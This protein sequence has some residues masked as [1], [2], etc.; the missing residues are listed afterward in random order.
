LAKDW[1]AVSPGRVSNRSISFEDWKI[2]EVLDLKLRVLERLS[3]QWMVMPIPLL[4]NS[5]KSGDA[6]ASQSKQSSTAPA[7]SVTSPA[8]PASALCF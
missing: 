8:F 6:T 1:W 4:E 2:L 7:T 5:Q 3:C